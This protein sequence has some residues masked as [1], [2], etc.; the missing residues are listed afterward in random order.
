MRVT[1]A[2][3]IFE[4]EPSAASFRL[5]ALASALVERGHEVSVLT[6]RPPKSMSAQVCDDERQYRVKRFPALRDPS[7]YVRGYLP[8]L[9]FD[10]PLFFRVLFGRR[11]DVVVAE[12]PPTTGL[13]V[14]LAAAIRRTPYVYYAADIWSDG[15]AQTGAPAWIVRAVGRVERFAMRG[16]ESVISVSDALTDRLGEIGIKQNVLTV[17]NGVDWRPFYSGSE[18]KEAYA[19]NVPVEF[20]YAGTASEWHG[21]TIFIEALP[22]VLTKFPDAR[23]RFIGGGSEF[24]KAEELANELGVSEA[25]TFEP[26]LP[27]AEL[28]PILRG[29][30]AALASILPGNGN[31]AT[32]PTK[33]YASTLCGT[34]AIFA[35]VGPAVKFLNTELSGEPLG[36]AVNLDPEAVAKAMISIALQNENIDQRIRVVEW[37]LAHVSLSSVAERIIVELEGIVSRD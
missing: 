34:P 35:G 30:T 21:S 9:S 3:R 27:P 16:A 2:S 26:F 36:L 32:F 13:F 8:Y 37:G 22:T 24:Q 4:P 11:T 10:L 20:V 23:I 12:P 17:G 25:V 14:R 15:A 29:A 18:P 19:R 5:G 1:I 33:L 31:E 28:A 7:G 6:V